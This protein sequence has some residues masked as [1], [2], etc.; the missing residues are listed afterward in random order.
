MTSLSRKEH[1]M[2]IARLNPMRR[3]TNRLTPWIAAP[4]PGYLFPNS[5]AQKPFLWQ[6]LTSNRLLDSPFAL[7]A[8]QPIADRLAA[9]TPCAKRRL[10]ILPIC[11]QVSATAS[12]WNTCCGKYQH[13]PEEKSPPQ[14]N[15]WCSSPVRHHVPHLQWQL[16]CYPVEQLW[17]NLC[18]WRRW[19]VIWASVWPNAVVGGKHCLKL[20]FKT[21][22]LS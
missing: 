14:R 15:L 8:V 13:H 4:A 7:Y 2:T 22:D 20:E 5:L 6:L 11:V 21:V 17:D 3:A 18:S 1:Q 10:S 12:Y 19:I 9:T 16:P